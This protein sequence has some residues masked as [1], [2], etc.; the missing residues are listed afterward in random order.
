MMVMG[1]VG[2]LA[3]IGVQQIKFNRENAYDRQAMALI[4]N[5]LTYAAIDEPNPPAGMEDQNGAGGSLLVYGYELEMPGSI[6][7]KIQNDAQDRWRF[8]FAHPGG[9]N[10]FY[11]WTPG[12][13]YSGSLDDDGFGNRSDKLLSNVSYRSDVGL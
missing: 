3:A 2:I 4:R 8:W 13:S 1:I 11:F 10:G 6:Y 9:Q 7:W 12:F 5:L